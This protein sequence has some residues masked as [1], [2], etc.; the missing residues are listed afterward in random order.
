MKKT[1][2]LS[3]IALSV[4]L[5]ACG[6]GETELPKGEPVAKVAAP[7]G[8]QWVDVVSKTAE[9]GYLIGNPDAPI[10]LVEYAALTCSHCAEFKHE[11]YEELQ[12]KYIA[13]GQMNFEVRN[14][15]LGPYDIPISILTR[16][17]GPEPYLALTDQFYAE[18][19][20]VL[21]QLQK[22][23]GAA[24]EA[25]LKRPE[26]ER[27]VALA[28][29]MGVIDF[30]TA[31]GISE[32]QAKACLADPANT[33]ELIDMTQV[34]SDPSGKYKVTGTPSFFLNG[35]PLEI[36][37]TPSAWTQVKTALQDAGAR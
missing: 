5:A 28:Q 10:Q 30:F 9:G 32:D 16:C 20:G 29:V 19:R 17:A 23:D 34:A 24:I 31:R 36:K 18:Q 15:L 33:K 11:A 2:L 6:G 7:D 12:S 35:A 8:K 4:A 22:A 25:A 27:F 21:E 3:V 13:S 37:A 26:E 1:G 14:F